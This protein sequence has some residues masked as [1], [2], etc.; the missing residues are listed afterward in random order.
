MVDKL[1]ARGL[2]HDFLYSKSSRE[3]EETVALPP[4]YEEG[5]H[6][7]YDA[8]GLIGGIWRQNSKRASKYPDQTEMCRL[9]FAVAAAPRMSPSGGWVTAVHF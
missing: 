7:T 3:G 5:R 6:A 9:V 4:L 2:L 8:A 1:A